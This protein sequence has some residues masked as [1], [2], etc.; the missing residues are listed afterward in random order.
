MLLNIVASTSTVFA[1]LSISDFSN[2]HNQLSWSHLH[3]VQPAAAP[4]TPSCGKNIIT[5]FERLKFCSG[6]SCDHKKEFQVL[7]Q[8]VQDGGG[9]TRVGGYICAL[10]QSEILKNCQNKH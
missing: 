1:A 7:L 9:E 10:E 3:P 6:A 8:V 5:I 4:G 2:T